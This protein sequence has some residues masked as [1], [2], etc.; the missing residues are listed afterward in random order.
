MTNP[1]PLIPDPYKQ[2]L[3]RQ[4]TKLAHAQR[5]ALS[6]VCD[7]RTKEPILTARQRRRSLKF[8]QI[9]AGTL[10]DNI[11]IPGTLAGA[12]AIY[13]FVLWNVA[14][15]SLILQ[16]GLTGSVNAI[17]LMELPEFPATSGFTLGFNGSWEMPH[18]EI[19]N[20]QPLILKLSAAARVTGFLRYSVV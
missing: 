3:T 10:G 13:E 18:W 19:D 4:H 2:L 12:K 17:V 5:Y 8:L 7:P 15:N 1:A 6:P 16:Q 11:I 9:N 20:G 14:T